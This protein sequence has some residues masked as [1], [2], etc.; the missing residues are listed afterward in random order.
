M[1]AHPVAIAAM[2]KNIRIF[3]ADDHSLTRTGVRMILESMK[4]VEVVG[5]AN[6]GREVQELAEKLR[7]DVI[8]MDIA[9]PDLNGIDATERIT[10][11]NGSAK[12]IILSSYSDETHVLSALR[13]G[14]VG[15]LLKNS[16]TTEL[17][18]AV[19]SV[20]EGQTFLSPLISNHVVSRV[21]TGQSQAK[22]PHALDTLTSRQRE[23]LQLIAEGNSTKEIAFLLNVSVKTVETHRTQLM[24]RLQINHI[25]G[26]VRF[27]LRT[28]LISE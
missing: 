10:K 20:A 24:E 25:A 21:L 6:N 12:I 15:Y 23:I 4:G 17:E 22:E 7:P 19:R 18:T 2:M 1:S 14:A 27:A 26:L 28:G 16:A 3:L 13:A 9:M 8:L 5:E 11:G